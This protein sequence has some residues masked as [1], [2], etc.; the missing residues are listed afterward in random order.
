MAGTMKLRYVDGRGV[1]ETVRITLAAAGKS[2]VRGIPLSHVDF[3]ARSFCKRFPAR[4]LASDAPS[5]AD[6][7]GCAL[8]GRSLAVL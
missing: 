5:I 3:C 4:S 8:P 1:A 7:G 6:D 2:E